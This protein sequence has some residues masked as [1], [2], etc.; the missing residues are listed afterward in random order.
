MKKYVP[1]IYQKTIFDINYKKLH[2]NGIKCLL[3]DLD[4]TLVAAHS[5]EPDKKVINLLK[6]LNKEFK[7]II[8]SNSSRKR[9][10][11]INSLF[12]VSYYSFSLK[13]LKRNFKKVIKDYQFTKE[14]IVLIGDQFITDILGGYRMGIKTILVDPLSND[15]PCTKLN[16]FLEGEIIN[17]LGKKN[18]FF[19]GKYYE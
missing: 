11:K 19:K 16:R 3:F 13:P 14:E 5:Y 7:V 9:L 4:N 6:K 18:L 15:L 17:R 8:I 12:N 10:E 1:A 2:K